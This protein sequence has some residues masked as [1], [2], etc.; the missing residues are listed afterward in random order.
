M[1]RSN[2]L[3][4]L[5]DCLSAVVRQPT[6]HVLAQ[7]KILIQSPGME[8]YLS[9]ELARRCGI[10]A[11]GQFPFPRAFLRQALDDGLGGGEG[12][13]LFE[14]ELMSWVLFDELRTLS[15]APGF[16]LI[17]HHLKDDTDG[18]RRLLL[19]ERLAYLFDQY[20]TYRPQLILSWDKESS[21]Q[22][23]QGRIWKRLRAR[24][25]GEHFAQRCGRYLKELS[26]QQLAAVLPER[27]SVF[28]GPGLPP[29]FLEMLAR[30]ARVIP[31]HVFSLTVCQHYFY[32]ATA[33]REQ[34]PLLQGTAIHPLL[35][36]MGQV[37]GDYQY[38]LEGLGTYHEGP[39]RFIP[40]LPST[41]S[42]SALSARA[43]TVVSRAKGRGADP[44]AQ[45]SLFDNPV[46]AEATLSSEQPSSVASSGSSSNTLLARLQQS[47]LEGQLSAPST[48]TSLAGDT[49]ISIDICHSRLREV[50]T[51]H[52][53]LLGWFSEDPSLRP[54]DIAVFA[55]DI[56]KYSSLVD[57]IFS[58][59]AGERPLIPYRIFD[60]SYRHEDP[61][62]RALLLG[63]QLLKSRFK[64][65]DVLDLLQLEP[66][67]ARYTISTNDLQR[68]SSWFRGAYIRCNVDSQHRKLWQLPQDDETTWRF[69]LRRLLLGYSLEDDGAQIYRSTVPY[70]DVTVGDGPLLGRLC[71]LC[72]RLFGLRDE[73]LSGGASGL[74]LEEW[75]RFLVS[76]ADTL[77]GEAKEGGWDLGAL[78]QSL[79]EL[80]ERRQLVDEGRDLNQMDLRFGHAAI[81]H[82][83]EEQLKSIRFASDFLSGG[84]TFCALL[85]LRNVPF[86]RVCVLGLNQGEFPR[87][88]NIDP[89]NLIAQHPLPGDRSLRADDRYIFLELLLSTRE[90][91][92]L[93]YVGRSVQDNTVIP[94]SVVVSELKAAASVLLGG[95]EVLSR[96]HPLQPF[97]FRYFS[98]GRK[99]IGPSF[100][101]NHF[102]G[103]LALSKKKQSAPPFLRETPPLKN[104]EPEVALHE[105]VRFFK[106]PARVFLRSFGVFLDPEEKTLVEREPTHLDALERYQVGEGLLRKLESRQQVQSEIELRRGALPLGAPGQSELQSLL[107]A[108]RSILAQGAA[109]RGAHPPLVRTID[110][111]LKAE[112]SAQLRELLPLSEVY[113]AA[114]GKFLDQKRSLVLS[115]SCSGLFG[116]LRVLQAFGK[117]NAKRK[118]TLWIEHL[119]LCATWPEFRGSV[120]VSKK[121]A[122]PSATVYTLG[123][124]PQGVARSS[125]GDLVA[126]YYV[127]QQFPLSF[128]PDASFE[129]ARR[130]TKKGELQAVELWQGALDAARKLLPQN[131]SF[132]LIYREYDPLSVGSREEGSLDELLFCRL[133][134]HLVGQIESCE[135]SPHRL[136]SM[137]PTQGAEA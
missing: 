26:D 102:L 56:E 54:E 133:A 35:A 82:L 119:A 23:L 70:D 42:L 106:D 76:L 110:L 57:A 49:S 79:F 2:S 30:I 24:C 32:D 39:A 80:E 129:F 115:G 123:A 11:G 85:P 37:G 83:V 130:V 44:S 5:V 96:E 12:A 25:P 55:P 109:L 14:R 74:T 3:D 50:E 114:L 99:R 101:K 33:S 90:T 105:M 75:T 60:R 69:G 124:V 136:L 107:E 64:V 68:L 20:I 135:L 51:L 108:A 117:P 88:D 15:T 94:P 113:R 41:S 43:R 7:E 9:R 128:F 118:L 13:N 45:L 122:G 29:L 28:G 104:P 6:K 78:R 100:E 95:G 131:A 93:S 19:A 97:H 62:A 61:A 112:V 137:Q 18:S 31:V 38:L 86:R 8:R 10:W 17:A 36:S 103:A 121:D 34:E 47:L 21:P 59:R 67:R 125:L 98:E 120:L 52:D 53:R 126:L 63:L 77:V 73:M 66:V 81:F 48:S 116:S 132:D 84:V 89:L 87:G 58:A 40:R 16:D 22:Q 72:D 92:S 71:E 1:Y 91:L 127:G 27:I 4:E 65:G 134:L 46:A 111:E